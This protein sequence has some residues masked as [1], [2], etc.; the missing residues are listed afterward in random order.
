MQPGRM[1]VANELKAWVTEEK[2]KAGEKFVAQVYVRTPY[3]IVATSNHE[4][5]LYTEAGDRRPCV[6]GTNPDPRPDEYY[7]EL[8]HKD[9]LRDRVAAFAH[10]LFA[11]DVSAFNPHAPPPMTSAKQT[12]IEGSWPALADAVAHL[13]EEGTGLCLDVMTVAEIR[14]T[15]E[16]KGLFTPGQTTDRKVSDAL[17]AL[18]WWSPGKGG[19]VW[20]KGYAKPATV[21]VSPNAPE[22]HR[23]K[24]AILAE[25]WEEEG[26]FELEGVV[27]I[28]TAGTGTVERLCER[29]RA[30]AAELQQGGR[31]EAFR[32]RGRLHAVETHTPKAGKAKRRTARERWEEKMGM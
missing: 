16:D 29:A 26:S 28:R 2:V 18:G 5:A 8:M 27:D 32:R 23:A 12:M 19:R 30:R 14:E 9:R 24:G 21:W 1:E 20:L 11:R 13:M 25:R 4:A 3:L 15:L 22:L 17:K 6:I 10:H 7:V 31:T